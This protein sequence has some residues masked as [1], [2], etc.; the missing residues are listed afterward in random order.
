MLE[1]YLGAMREIARRVRD[2]PNVMGFDSLNE[3]TPGWIGQSLSYRHLGPSETN[4]NRAMPGLAW[5]PIDGLLVSHGVARSIPVLDF[6]P[7]T[8]T[9]VHKRDRTINPDHISIWADDRSD[10][11]EQAGAWKLNKDGTFD[12]LRDD[13]FQRVGDRKV[14][15][16]EDY[17]G[18]FFARV[19]ESMR[20]INPD[21]ILFAE[22]DPHSGYFGP[23]FPADT[24][25]NTV[26]AGSLVRRGDARDQDFQSELQPR[27]DDRR[28]CGGRRRI[29]GALR[30]PARQNRENV[31]DE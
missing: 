24:P 22:L 21:W 26:N 9:V 10:P 3:P 12:I 25:P 18:P 11:F 4:P 14:N 20:E 23:G 13:F 2:L 30:T 31:R 16:I 27:R 15:F 17:M 19:A 7:A 5:S 8:K 28:N 6:D 29:A 1:H